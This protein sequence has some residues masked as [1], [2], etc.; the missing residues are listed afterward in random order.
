MLL[1][2][3]LKKLFRPAVKSPEQKLRETRVMLDN[4]ISEALAELVDCSD[5]LYAMSERDSIAGWQAQVEQIEYL[6][7]RPEYCTV[8]GLETLLR[9]KFRVYNV[10]DSSLA[11]L[12]AFDEDED[13]IDWDNMPAMEQSQ[14]VA[15]NHYHQRQFTIHRQL[16]LV[17]RFAGVSERRIHDVLHIL[18]AHYTPVE[19]RPLR[20]NEVAATYFPMIR[21]WMDGERGSIQDLPIPAEFS[22]WMPEHE[23]L[24]PVLI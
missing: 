13:E 19:D 21:A 3:P 24:F 5:E 17:A 9:E 1:L 8:Q 4:W 16:N 7:E 6:L 11:A 15:V 14:R 2:E 23:S 22:A 20:K 12:P 18:T 10:L